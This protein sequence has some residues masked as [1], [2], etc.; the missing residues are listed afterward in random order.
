MSDV[1]PSQSPSFYNFGKKSAMGMAGQGFSKIGSKIA[2]KLQEGKNL[3]K[4]W[5]FA[6]SLHA[7]N[8]GISHHYAMERMGFQAQLGRENLSH[9]AGIVKDLPD[10][11]LSME[12]SGDGGFR[13][14]A[15]KAPVSRAAS[16]PAAKVSAPAAPE[17]P[18]AA[19]PTVRKNARS[20]A[21]QP[22][23]PKAAIPEPVAQKPRT[24]AEPV[25]K[26]GTASSKAAPT[27]SANPAAKPTKPA[28]PKGVA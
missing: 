7:H 3:Q 26:M 10:R 21:A 5:E 4:Q 23:A 16:K 17:A 11:N 8:E 24:K 9:A 12:S 18:A 25:A 13:F 6:A 20:M 27:V 28:K 1:Q 22:G 2:K 15:K 14:D 19:Q